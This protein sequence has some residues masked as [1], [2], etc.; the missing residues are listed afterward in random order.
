MILIYFIFTSVLASVLIIKHNPLLVLL[1]RL[2]NVTV[3]ASVHIRE[4]PRCLLVLP[5]QVV[6]PLRMLHRG[7]S[8]VYLH[9][10][11]R[12]LLPF[13]L[14]HFG[15]HLF[16]LE[17]FLLDHHIII[18]ILWFLDYWFWGGRSG[19]LG[20]EGRDVLLHDPDD[21]LSLGSLKTQS[22]QA[23]VDLNVFKLCWNV[24]LWWG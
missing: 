22:F 21:S 1:N 13:L 7:L 15:D 4:P 18:L 20:C 8:G 6:R 5:R 24:L 12:S 2:F 9:W 11:H 17:C 16:L 10:G 3:N 23:L 19:Y 14:F